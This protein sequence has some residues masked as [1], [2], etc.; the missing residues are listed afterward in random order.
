MLPNII[1]VICAVIIVICLALCLLGYYE[2]IHSVWF[3]IG[4]ICGCTVF[5]GTISANIFAQDLENKYRELVNKY[6]GVKAGQFSYSETNGNRNTTTSIDLTKGQY[7]SSSAPTT[8]SNTYRTNNTSNT[9]VNFNG[10]A[11]L[12][13]MAANQL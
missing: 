13:N 11:Q 9:T 4:L 12:A 6:N 1:N 10:I 3:M 2:I 8:G 7:N 5:F